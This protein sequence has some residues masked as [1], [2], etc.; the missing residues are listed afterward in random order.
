[1]VKFHLIAAEAT[2]NVSPNFVKKTSQVINIISAKQVHFS[3]DKT[4]INYD[5]NNKILELNHTFILLIDTARGSAVNCDY[6]LRGQM[7]LL[8]MSMRHEVWRL[9]SP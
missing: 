8:L 4:R 9:S 2:L 7:R 3:C 5:F 1:M 6:A